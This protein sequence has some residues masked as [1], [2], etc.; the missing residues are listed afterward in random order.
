MSVN[1]PTIQV[2]SG[3]Q[4]KV[5][6]PVLL[7]ALTSGGSVVAIKTA[8]DG[9]IVQTNASG[10]GAVSS[11]SFSRP[12]DTTA[13]ASGDLVGNSTTAGSVTPVNLLNAV[14][15]AGGVSRV[16]RIRLSKSGTSITNTS[17]RV[18]LY[19]A[20]PT[21][22]NGDNG[23][24]V[25]TLSGYIGSYDVTMDRTYSDG[26]IGIGT[27]LALYGAPVFTV[28]GTTLYALIEARAAY[29][30]ASGET[31]TVTAELYRF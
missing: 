16:E 6:E 24:F 30:P 8:S 18:H 27:P 21:V 17:F 20:A 4:T 13:Y 28:A 14:K 22:T 25:S 26:A 23:A 1:I 11:A 29:T 12:A 2:G 15:E 5:V 31:F 10:F 9:S 7:T 3:N 19:S